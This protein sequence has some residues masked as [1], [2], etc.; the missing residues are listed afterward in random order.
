[1]WSLRDRVRFQQALRHHRWL[2][3]SGAFKGVVHCLLGPCLRS[4]HTT[5]DSSDLQQATTSQVAERH[6]GFGSVGKGDVTPTIGAAPLRCHQFRGKTGTQSVKAA[7]QLAKHSTSTDCQ[8]AWGEADASQVW[9]EA[10]FANHEPARSLTAFTQALA[11]PKAH[12]SPR[13]R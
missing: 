8:Y 9:G 5:S 1:M 4:D 2:N 10:Y 3:C 7:T 13:R 12:R 11:G 6:D